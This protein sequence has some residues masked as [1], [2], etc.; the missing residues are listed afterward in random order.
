MYNGWSC[1]HGYSIIENHSNTASVGP[2]LAVF[3]WFSI[4][5]Y[6]TGLEF[7]IDPFRLIPNP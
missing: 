1:T 7:R 3:E 2:T 5:E 4:M 6:C